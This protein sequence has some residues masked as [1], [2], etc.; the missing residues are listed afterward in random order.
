[1]RRWASHAP[2]Q[3]GALEHTAR[4]EQTERLSRIIETQRDVAA[5][6]LDLDLVMAVICERTQEL[7]DAESAT[8]LL[9]DR[10]REALEQ[11]VVLQD[12]PLAI[13]ASIG[14]SLFPDDGEDVDTL[15]QRADVAMYTAK[16]ENSAYAF[17]D[18]A[19]DHYDPSR[20]TL[21][22]ELR[23]AIEER[24]LVLHYQPKAVLATGEVRSVEALLRW[25]HPQRGLVLPDDFIPLA[26]QTGLIKPLILE[27]LS[28]MGIRL[29]IDDFGTDYSSL[30]YLKRLP[31]DEI[32][33]DRSFVMSMGANEDD[34][35]IVRSTIDLGRNLDL[36]V[37]AEGVETE[38]V[39]NELSSLGC[40]SAQ[41]Y[42]LSRPVPPEELRDWL[43]ERD[44]PACT[45]PGKPPDAASCEGQRGRLATIRRSVPT[46]SVS[47]SQACMPTTYAVPRARQRKIRWFPWLPPSGYPGAST[48]APA[49]PPQIAR[50]R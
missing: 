45:R 1:M 44:T 11:P 26:Q 33:I 18:E 8:I 14:V 36:D 38:E 22:A 4:R 48:S 12:L 19:S 20:L 29:S 32:K 17:Y 21:V 49:F 2:I 41:G 37:V 50:P 46:A 39:W 27:R 24:E 10:V 13:E 47:G 6:G 5:A 31:V 43:R 28:S 25:N 40:P 42:Y 15:L 30:A 9:L 35:A 7:T 16:P 34:A 23:R 3:G